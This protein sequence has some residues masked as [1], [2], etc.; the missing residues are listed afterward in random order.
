MI[1]AHTLQARVYDAAGQL[2]AS[3]IISVNVGEG[4]A[5]TSPA[6][7]ATSPPADAT[8]VPT[9]PAEPTATATPE[10]PLVTA[11]VNANVRGGPGLNYYV[12]GSLNEGQ[13]AVVTGR[14]AD[15][16]W[17]QISYQGSAA[18]IA[19]SVVTANAQA[20][21]VPVASAPPPPPTSTSVPPTATPA[22][23][24]TSAPTTGFWADQ[25]SLSAG[26]CTAL[27]WNLT[28][29]KAVYVSFGFGYDKQGVAGQGSQQVCPSVTT[30]YEA[31]IVKPDNSQETR[32][33]TINVS[34]GGCGDPIIRQFAPT[35]YEVPAGKP[36]SIFWD[37]E[38]AKSVR[39]VRV[40]GAEEPVTGKGSKIDVTVQDD[41]TFQLKVEKT[42]GGYVYASFKINAK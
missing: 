41:T 30:N 26:Q 1:G 19:N 23:S 9:Q 39:F 2:G 17:W 33:V 29:I 21:N 28:N 42:G 10:Q 34:G 12:I 8:A 22:P 38:C 24:A 7:E 6:P 5:A 32:T 14:N 13:S 4:P 18:W 15:S 31:L 36:F 3:P 27:N 16:S 25:T 11:D 35:T 20:A 37:V 40:G